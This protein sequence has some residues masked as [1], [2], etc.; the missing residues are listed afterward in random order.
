[1]KTD[2]NRLTRFESALV[3]TIVLGLTIVGFEIF[4]SLPDHAQ[5]TVGKSLGIFDVNETLQITQVGV[6][7]ILAVTSQVQNMFALELANVLAISDELNLLADYANS[8]IEKTTLAV[9]AIYSTETL[10]QSGK[11][12]GE[13]TYNTT[14]TECGKKVSNAEVIEISAQEKYFNTYQTPNFSF[15]TQYVPLLNN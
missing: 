8:G 14:F 1:M 12:L 6:G 9:N 4:M 11:V 13:S 10:V 3:V 15:I 5:V 2:F 7:E